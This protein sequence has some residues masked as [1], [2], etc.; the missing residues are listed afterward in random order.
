MR[1][2]L[3]FALSLNLFADFIPLNAYE[4][5]ELFE[6][7]VY[8]A[9]ENGETVL[10]KK[11]RIDSN[12]K[13]RPGGICFF[14]ND[15]FELKVDYCD[16]RSNLFAARVDISL[17]ESG[18]SY[19]VYY[20]GDP[21]QYEVARSAGYMFYGYTVD[22]ICGF[23]YFPQNGICHIKDWLRGFEFLEINKTSE[24]KEDYSR[25][26]RRIKEFFI[27]KANSEIDDIIIE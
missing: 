13:A 19:S 16:L 25:R 17:I 27:E 21:D 18:E 5:L 8:Q 14:S 3:V 20:E 12:G 6:E 11:D 1:A 22:H 9:I 2:L 4:I 24:E 26:F 7:K 23:Q 10:S 15:E